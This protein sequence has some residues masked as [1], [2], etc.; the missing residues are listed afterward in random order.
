MAAEQNGGGL[1]SPQP[2]HHTA[3]AQNLI[4]IFLTGAASHLDTF[5]LKPDA[6]P[7]VRGEFK[8]TA[9]KVAGVH[10]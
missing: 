8:P 7:E 9:T 3:K 1:L 6:P 10:V 5:D 2:A 4:V